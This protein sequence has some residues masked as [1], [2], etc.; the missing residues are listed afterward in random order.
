M[1]VRPDSNIQF[2]TVWKYYSINP[3]WKSRLYRKTCV[4]VRGKVIQFLR[5]KLRWGCGFDFNQINT[6]LDELDVIARTETDDKVYE[7]IRQKVSGFSMGEGRSESRGN[8][9]L[10]FIPSVSNM[11]DVGCGDGSITAHIG[12]ELKLDKSNIHGCDVYVDKNL[13]SDIT[14]TLNKDSKLPYPSDSFDLVTAMMSL[15]HIRDVES[16]IGEIHRV[17]K[18]NG[19]FLIREHDKDVDELVLFLDIVHGLYS[20]SL[21]D[22]PEDPN[23]RTNYYATYRSKNEW[24]RIIITARFKPVKTFVEP[25][26]QRYYYSSYTKC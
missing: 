9:M 16:M 26:S 15:H 1:I 4:S 24:D 6:I 8:V 7:F 2:K 11:L 19:T 10:D 18:P 5:N 23:F 25:S 14:F 13:S 3:H 12:S 17:L 20:L 21:K 22:E